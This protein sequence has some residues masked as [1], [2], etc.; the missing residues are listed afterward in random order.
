MDCFSGFTDLLLE[1]VSFVW[2]LFLVLAA[3]GFC[4]V[5]HEA[6]H[7][8]AGRLCG[9]H[10]DAFA[11]G[12]KPFW[13]KKIRG[14]EYRLGWLPF[15]GYVELPQIDAAVE[16]PKTAGGEPLK[17]AKPLHRI[18]TAAAGPLANILSGLALGCAVWYYGIPQT[19]PR[20]REITVRAVDADSPEYRAGLRAGD[21][22][23]K[24]NGKNFFLTWEQ[25]TKEII[26]SRGRITLD[27]AGAGNQIRKIVYTPEV[28][29]KVGGELRE[30]AVAY[31]FFSPQVP[32]ELTP[33]PESPAEKAGI[34]PGDILLSAG[35]SPMTDFTEFQQLISGNGTAPLEVQVLRADRTVDLTVIPEKAP[36]TA[37]EE[38]LYTQWLIGIIY[39]PAPDG[40][41]I[42]IIKVLP[43]YP[44]EK[45]GLA[46]DDT[47][48]TADGRDLGEQTDLKK[49]LTE[50][51]D[52][53]VKLAIRRGEEN[54]SVEITAA[55]ISPHT[56]GV[57][58]AFFDRP[59]PLQQFYDT[60][61]TSYRT[62][63]A[64]FGNLGAKMGIS[65]QT[66]A[67]KP[68]NMSGPLGI[69]I[70][71]FTNIKNSPFVITV[72]FLVMISFALAIFNLLPL[73]VLDGGHILFGVIELVF[74]K[75]LP[76]K[77]VKALN[78][79]FAG[80]LVALMIYITVFADTPRL[81]RKI[82]GGGR[83]EQQVEK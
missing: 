50:A 25:F 14:V 46:A 77:L 54:L 37:E 29:S 17:P 47:V 62:L 52:R 22:I 43:G 41:G 73:P 48:L 15:G 4:I 57:T 49:I 23:V 6:G 8:L 79:T 61:E 27:A 78:Y 80:L 16:T 75:P 83:Q 10:I 58:M 56:I 31:P 28:N 38:I 70:I 51:Q 7:F 35:G 34:L 5:S 36:L 74:R 82:S 45:A 18:I 39:R 3:I 64:M 53:P 13:R 26:L 68:R 60:C 19:T 33:L 67:I 40:N 12:F 65:G 1:S 20:M 42:K 72:Y 11:L 24:L 69:G 55:K 76:V 9:L 32:I 71:L 44:G 59:T 30:E 63:A 66:S 2:T 81:I 21:R